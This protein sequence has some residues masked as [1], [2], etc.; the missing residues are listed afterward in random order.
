M[1]PI[2]ELLA[3]PVYTVRELATRYGASVNT[4]KKWIVNGRFC[5]PDGRVSAYRSHTGL[6]EWLVLAEAVSW[7]EQNSEQS[8]VVEENWG[9]VTVYRLA[10]EANDETH[11]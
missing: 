11:L 3:Q 6:R 8:A 4:I 5:L 10:T 7:Y 2:D 1:N 9:T